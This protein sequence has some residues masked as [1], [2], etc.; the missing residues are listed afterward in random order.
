MNISL[1]DEIY[2][3]QAYIQSTIHNLRT[4]KVCQYLLWQTTPN[5][6]VQ[7]R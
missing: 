2:Q 1:T 5:V 6:R 4:A 3:N 7:W